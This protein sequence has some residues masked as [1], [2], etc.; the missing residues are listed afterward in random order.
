MIAWL[1]KL[2]Q[3]NVFVVEKQWRQRYATKKNEFSKWNVEENELF[4]C[5]FAIYVFENFVIR[6]KILRMNH[7]D[8]NVEYFARAKIE[9]VIK[10]KYF[11]FDIIKKITNYVRICSNYQ[12]M[13][14][15]Q[16]KSYDDMTIISFENEK[17]FNIVIMNFI[18]NIFFVKDFYIEKINDS[19]LILINKLT[20]HAIYITITKT[21]NAIS[22]A[23]LLWRKFICRHKMMR[24]IIFDRNSLF[25]NNFWFTLCWN[26]KIKR[27][28]NIA[29]YSQTNNQTKKQNVVFKQYLR[30]YCNYK[31]NNWSKLLFMTTFV[32]NNSK[33]SNI[34]QIFQE[35]LFE[36]VANLEIEFVNNFQKRET[37]LTTNRAKMLR[38]N[39]T[40]LMNL[41]KRI[42]KQQIKYYNE[43]YIMKSFESKEKMLLREINIRILRLKKKIDYK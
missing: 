30:I 4:R 26:L 38:N 9:N 18:T 34:D 16:H 25:T 32:Y 14:I 5:D 43:N 1:F 2:Q 39:K 19:I 41:W 11:W 8:S 29:F 13:R 33:H 42:S 40:H 6:E 20:K 21:L 12:R 37:T 31:Q 24:N 28:L 10:R 23:N 35:F 27:K 3:K 36:C 15:H 7:D 22:F 17:S